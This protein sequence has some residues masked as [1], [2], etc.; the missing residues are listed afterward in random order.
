MSNANQSS[1]STSTRNFISPIATTLACVSALVSSAVTVLERVPRKPWTVALFE[2]HREHMTT[3]VKENIVNLIEED[4]KR[5]LLRAPVKSGKRE[6]SE[7]L[8][9]RDS[10]ENSPRFHIF[11]SGW[12][13]VADKLQRDELNQHN[14]KVFS[15]NNESVI[16][17]CI[18]YVTQKIA[19]NKTCI[20]H[21]DECDYGTGDNQIVNNVY[22]FLRNNENVSIILYSATPEEAL[23]SGDMSDMCES[24]KEILDDMCNGVHVE[25]I[26]PEGYCGPSRFLDEG[27]VHSATPF[28]NLESSSPSLTPQG[29]EII[30]GVRREVSLR[31]GRNIVVLRMTRGGGGEKKRTSKANKEIYM[32]LK[33]SHLIPELQDINIWVA[34]SDD[35]SGKY[36]NT[37]IRKQNVSWD[38]IHF[39]EDVTT[40]SPILIVIDQTST[41]STEWSCHNR[42]Y[43]THDFRTSIQYSTVSQAQERCNHYDTKYPGGF[44]PIHIYGH[45]KTFLLSAKRI[46][47]NEYFTIEWNKFKV[48]KRRCEKLGLVGDYYEIKST[49]KKAIHP[50]Y[51]SFMSLQEANQAL[52][53]LDCFVSSVGLAGR[54]KGDVRSLPVFKTYWFECNAETFPEK[55]AE[56]RE[57]EETEEAFKNCS[58]TYAPKNPFLENSRPPAREDGMEYGQLRGWNILDYD[59]HIVNQPGWGLGGQTKPRYT[60]CYND[61]VLGVALRW[62]TEEFEQKDSLTAYKSMYGSRNMDD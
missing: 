51:N 11:L 24:E 12:H 9:M 25:Y 50:H 30:A 59:T 15:L 13:R 47:Y 22:S 16:D 34:N 48:D 40:N 43:A 18:A 8:A 53:N 29:R 21:L 55:F 52:I 32:F 41:R 23:F 10:G 2:T 61:G 36:E 49:E 37:R 20:A 62:K 38:D 4:Y 1:S 56:I 3:W 6:I 17:D 28:A 19:E 42:L 27:L 7:Y 26:P 14:M 44:Q 58:A 60:I 54:V 46:D 33:K 35:S 5:I 39:W 45:V 57:S 31:T